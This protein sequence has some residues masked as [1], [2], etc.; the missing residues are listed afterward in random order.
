LTRRARF[1]SH[2]RQ[3]S[4]VGLQRKRAKR[5]KVDVVAAAD[6]PEAAGVVAGIVMADAVA[7]VV[8]AAEAAETAAET[9]DN[10]IKNNAKKRTKLPSPVFF[11]IKQAGYFIK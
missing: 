10:R 4:K 9:E 3:Y 11:I 2:D 1:V 6:A 7:A 8:I 5:T